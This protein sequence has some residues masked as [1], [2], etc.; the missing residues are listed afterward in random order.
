MKR[1]ILITFLLAFIL[2]LCNV[3]LFGGGAKGKGEARLRQRSLVGSINGQP[4]PSMNIK[5]W[6]VLIGGSLVFLF[7]A[8][9]KIILSTG[10]EILGLFIALWPFGETDERRSAGFKR[11]IL[12]GSLLSL[13]INSYA[14]SEIS[15]PS[16]I[17]GGC[18]AF[19]PW[20]KGKLNN[21]DAW[22]CRNMVTDREKSN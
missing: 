2:T 12:G 16:V 3:D 6:R 7:M 20:L 13:G 19:W 11:V 18:I 17:A 10:S 4:E 21:L 8:N 22:M 15:L 1:L 5:W 14:Y 9:D